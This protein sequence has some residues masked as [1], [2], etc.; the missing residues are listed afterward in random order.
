MSGV[1][2]AI[3]GYY[4]LV[5]M[6]RIAGRRPGKQL[7]PVDFIL[8]FFSGGLILTATVGDD[9]S[10]TNAFAQ[11]A[12]IAAAHYLLVVMRGRWPAIGRV[13]DGTPLVLLE[14]GHWKTQTMKTMLIQ[15]SDVMA[16]ARDQ[17]IEN[18]EQIDYAVLER[19]GQISIIRK[20][21]EE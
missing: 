20:E 21:N 14:G 15:D 9:R 1:L 2:R 7:T 4:F 19:N 6:M 18:L 12:A 13:V 11:I 10:L 8:V 5:F 16:T 3:L 17:G